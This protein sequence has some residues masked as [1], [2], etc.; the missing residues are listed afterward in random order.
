MLC[1]SFEP[2]CLE[3]FDVSVGLA[4]P[5]EA[6]PCPGRRQGNSFVMWILLKERKGPVVTRL[7]FWIPT[8]AGRVPVEALLHFHFAHKGRPG[9]CI[10]C[11]QRCQ[12]GLGSGSPSVPLP[13]VYLTPSEW[14]CSA[15]HRH[16]SEQF[17]VSEEAKASRAAQR[18]NRQ[19]VHGCCMLLGAE[20]QPRLPQQACAETQ[21]PAVC[22]GGAGTIAQILPELH[23]G[24][25][26]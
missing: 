23:L 24:H 25:G 7:Q 2:T 5:I 19:C 4:G 14:L 3:G 6:A 16:L 15:P 22:P 26:S 1:G 17:V 21:L 12:V 13:L 9:G 20:P 11:S 8:E 18:Q 10:S